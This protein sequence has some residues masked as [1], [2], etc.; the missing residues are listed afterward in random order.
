MNT[1]KENFIRISENRI[2]KIQQLIS[3]LTNLSNSSFYEYTDEEII[4]MFNIIELETKNA[5]N[6]LLKANEKKRK[7]KRFEL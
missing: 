2:A 4:K 6:F 7:N 5:K 3:Q 1:K